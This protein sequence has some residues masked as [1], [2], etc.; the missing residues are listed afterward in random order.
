LLLPPLEFFGGTIIFFMASHGICKV[1]TILQRSMMQSRPPAEQ[2]WCRRRIGAAPA[3]PTIFDGTIIMCL[4]LQG[5]F[6]INTT[7]TA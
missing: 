7:F 2:R 3:A 5:I 1:V 6:S 4:A